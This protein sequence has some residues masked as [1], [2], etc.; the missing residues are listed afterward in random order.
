MDFPGARL[1]SKRRSRSVSL[2][3]VKEGELRETYDFDRVPIYIYIDI[4]LDI[5][6]ISLNVRHGINGSSI[7]YPDIYIYIDS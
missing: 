7:V 5:V 4:Y 3:V 6:P 1:A 2:A